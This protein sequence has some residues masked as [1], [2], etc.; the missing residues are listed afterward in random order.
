MWKYMKGSAYA[1]ALTW[2]WRNKEKIFAFFKGGMQS[3][4]EA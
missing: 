4:R 3:A 1:A 2:G